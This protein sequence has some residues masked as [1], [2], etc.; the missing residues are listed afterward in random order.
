M[1]HLP[2]PVTV[3]RA[4]NTDWSARY[5]VRHRL[6][7]VVD[8]PLGIC[9][10]DKVRVY[11]RRE[12][13]MLQWWD[14]GAKKSLSTRVDGDLIDALARAREIDVR[15][16]HLKTSGPGLRRLRHGDLV[17]RYTEDLRR[18]AEAGELAAK[19]VTR[20]S[21]ALRHY[22]DF[23]GQLG[24]E[25]AFPFT[26]AVNREFRLAFSA[27][28][29]GLQVAPN[30]H[31]HAARRPLRGQRYV[32]EAARGMFEW[33]ADP[34]R[35]NL[36]PA[37]F[38]NPFRRIGPGQRAV[39]PDQFGE[40]DISLPMAVEFLEAC[41]DVQLTLFGTLLLYGLRATEPV[42]LFHEQ[43][44]AGWVRISCLPEL[45]YV[46]KGKRDKRFP[47]VPALGHLWTGAG[48]G[49]VKHGLLLR[50]RDA[51][52]DFRHVP[53]VGASLQELCAEFQRR[54]R[55][56]PSLTAT[57]RQAIRDELIQA[58]GGLSYD[59]IAREFRDVARRLSWPRQA[60]LKDFRHLFATSLENAGVGEFYRR[61]F[62][63][64]S[65]GRAPIV[66]YTHLNR[67]GDQFQKVLDQDFGPVLA[68]IARR[69]S[70]RA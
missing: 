61:Y 28:L 18:R 58:A 31:P 2:S 16:E 51:A 55:E 54:C 29:S 53:W 34:N 62:L 36:L 11:R 60:T 20:Y 13:F 5:G 3:Q 66:T 27:Y 45:G 30:G 68:V 39:A 52:A 15:L 50:R 44:D 67:L 17:D 26:V 70:M 49:A 65:P 46:T 12:H 57:V 1:H 10:P 42:Y 43:V 8:F 47:V 59:H 48:T 40:P 25:K 69:G 14:R 37:G 7:R 33:A 32:L 24:T 38:A 23:A 9:P 19:T 56:T 4:S 21:T 35:G 41:D 6:V 64:Q 22:R 63:G